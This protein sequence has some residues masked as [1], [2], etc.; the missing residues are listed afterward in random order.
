MNFEQTILFINTGRVIA[1]SSLWCDLYVNPFVTLIIE[2]VVETHISIFS[3]EL[4]T[5][6]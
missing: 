3:D 4:I 2:F 6:V 5:F 1:V